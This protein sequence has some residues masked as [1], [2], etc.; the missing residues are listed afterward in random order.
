LSKIDEQIAA[1]K[2]A[3]LE[4][5]ASVEA[6]AAAVEAIVPPVLTV[7]DFGAKGDGKTDDTESLRLAFSAGVFRIPAGRYMVDATKTLL[8]PVGAEVVMDP[9]TILQ[10]I[11]NASPKYC[12]LRTTAR[13][14]I[15]GGQ[16]LGDRQNHTYVD[17]GDKYR[18]HEWGYGIHVQGTDCEVDGTII[19]DCTGDGLAVSG[20]DQVIRNVISRNNRRQGL[21]LFDSR[22]FRA[23]DCK[24]LLT[25]GAPNGPCC[26]VD[27]EPDEGGE[28]VD[29]VFERCEASD[30]AR[31]GFVALA[32]STVAGNIS[33]TM[34]DCVTNNNAN[35]THVKG[36]NG[37]VTASIMGGTHV[38]RAAGARIE[39]G[40][41]LRVSGATFAFVGKDRSDFEVTGTDTRTKWDL[42]VLSGGILTAGLNFYR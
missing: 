40:A 12:V 14:K 41:A 18:T 26:G 17:T 8:L 29:A 2:A 21:S 7:R 3:V 36:L 19:S 10:V 24:F 22:R 38:N 4:L 35:G 39:T 27:M 15:L 28:I 11:P 34:I 25:N 1:A 5:R 33:F 32:R 13:N 37:K 30:N 9:D 16:V 20:D 6:L 31:S 23:Y 42:Q